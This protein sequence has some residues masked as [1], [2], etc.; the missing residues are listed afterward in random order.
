[1]FMDGSHL[2]QK[3]YDDMPYIAKWDLIEP[4]DKAI[5]IVPGMLGSD[6][7]MA[8]GTIA[9]IERSV[10]G[11][12]EVDNIEMDEDGYSINMINSVNRDNYGADDTYKTIYDEI[13]ASFGG[14][15]DVIFFDYDFRLSNS[16]AA[17]KLQQEVSCYDEV[18]FVAHSNGGLVV[19]KYLS[20]NSNNRSKTTSFIS[21]G[22]P[23]AGSSKCNYV[24][25][26]GGMLD[27]VAAIMNSTI[28][29]MSI[30][31]PGAYELLPVST[32]NAVTHLSPIIVD[33][34]IHSNAMQL[35]QNATWARN[36]SGNVKPMFNSAISFHSS[37]L[38][39]NNKHIIHSDEVNVY[40]IA[41]TNVETIS[42]VFYD[43]EYELTDLSS[44]TD[45]DGTVLRLSAGY[46][47]PDF[48]YSNVDHMDLITDSTVLNKIKELITTDTGISATTSYIQ[49]NKVVA[50][51]V[52][53]VELVD[54]LNVN[55]KGWILGY[56]NRRIKINTD[57][58]AVVLL[59]DLITTEIGEKVYDSNGNRIGSVWKIGSSKKIYSLYDG[60][61]TIENCNHAVVMYM[62][63]GYYRK[64]VEYDS[65]LEITL[66][67]SDY[68]SKEI[69]CVLSDAPSSGTI[70]V[71][72]K[73][74][75]SNE[76]TQMN[77]LS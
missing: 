66:T 62:N 77:N 55:E 42:A 10:N 13:Y 25:E 65:G 49:T 26:G 14:S 71:P 64:V 22:T 30:N 72:S 39:S 59:D 6:L 38:D 50:N 37:L 24:F 73:I 70:V 15:F 3:S 1:M 56:D 35:L 23:Y 63:D 29:S 28:S 69:S 48:V 7:Q 27:G 68:S 43:S 60:D 12:F 8:D 11:V 44:S 58:D 74:Y 33:L 67:V 5:V 57:S 20:N 34:V 51:S 41:G 61:Y 75:S 53:K 16:L 18:V 45:G 19:S 52:N 32:Y 46:G 76:L 4:K 31:S 2:Q 36:S 47:T 54:N 9:W 21:L 17:N 40:T